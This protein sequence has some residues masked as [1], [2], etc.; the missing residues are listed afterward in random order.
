MTAR[1]GRLDLHRVTIPGSDGD[2][3][4]ECVYLEPLAALSGH[5]RVDLLCGG[6]RES[7]GQG[8]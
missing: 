1:S 8:E 7:R 4:A 5:G 2:V 3:S 6:Q